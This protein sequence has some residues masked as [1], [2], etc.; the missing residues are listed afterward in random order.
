LSLRR[1]NGM[2]PDGGRNRWAQRKMCW[3]NEK[4]LQGYIL[5]GLSG[6]LQICGISIAPAVGYRVS[7]SAAPVAALKPM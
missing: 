5:D 4:S 6:I 2:L 1:G 7:C 3:R